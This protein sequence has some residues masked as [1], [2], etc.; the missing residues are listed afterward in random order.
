M[1]Q[2][3]LSCPVSLT[4]EVTRVTTPRELQGK[5]AEA[6]GDA[7]SRAWERR[8][9]NSDFGVRGCFPKEV[10]GVKLGTCEGARELGAARRHPRGKSLEGKRGR[11]GSTDRRGGEGP[12]ARRRLNRLTGAACVSLPDGRLAPRRDERGGGAARAASH[13]CSATLRS[14]FAHR[15][16]RRHRSRADTGELYVIT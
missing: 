9:I 16:Q 4:E 8:S 6:P 14:A 15:H 2:R 7:A 13:D 3:G 5:G 12:F 10:M 1:T 11:T